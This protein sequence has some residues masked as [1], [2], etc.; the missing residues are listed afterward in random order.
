MTAPLLDFIFHAP[1]YLGA[2]EN[3]QVDHSHMEKGL[4]AATASTMIP[5]ISTWQKSSQTRNMP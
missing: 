3:D 4:C 1:I 2:W 5:A